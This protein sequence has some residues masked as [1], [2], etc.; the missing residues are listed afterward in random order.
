MYMFTMCFADLFAADIAASS[1][2]HGVITQPGAPRV[3]P[4]T[5]HSYDEGLLNDC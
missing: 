3:I 5:Q 1:E 2:Q 4:V